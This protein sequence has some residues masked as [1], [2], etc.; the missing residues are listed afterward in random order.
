MF[1]TLSRSAENQSLA[2]ERF[3]SFR[4]KRMQNADG[5][6]P[7]LASEMCVPRGGA[8]DQSPVISAPSPVMAIWALYEISDMRYANGSF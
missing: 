3:L 6:K 7:R 1:S 4:N 5:L 2:Y 8:S